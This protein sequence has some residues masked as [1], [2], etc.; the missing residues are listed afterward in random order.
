MGGLFLQSSQTPGHLEQDD[1][2][3]DGD[4]GDHLQAEH[5]LHGDKQ[6]WHIEGL[7]KHLCCLL[8][9]LTWVEWGFR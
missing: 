5:G 2:R 3:E 1:P 8:P 6:G 9:V 4:S 7:K